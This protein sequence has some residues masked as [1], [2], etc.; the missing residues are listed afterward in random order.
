MSDVVSSSANRSSS[1]S[2]LPAGA[3]SDGPLTLSDDSQPPPSTATSLDPTSLPS[4]EALI[5]HPSTDLGVSVPSDASSSVHQTPLTPEVY[6]SGALPPGTTLGHYVIRS[7]IGGG[8][9]GRVYLATDS[10]LDRKVAIK[11]LPRQ[12]ANDQGTVARFMNEAK[13]AARLNHEH[14]AQVYFA[15][16]QAGIPFIVFEYVEGTNIRALVEENGVFTVPQAINFLIQI[17]HALAHAADHGVVHRDVKPSNILITS[18]GR[19]KLI[20]M[21]LARLLDPSE[22]KADLTASGVTLGTF[23]YIS[24]EQARDPRAADIRS[25]IY[26]LGCTFFYMLTG[27]PPF[28]EGTVLQKLLQHQG[29]LA[30]DVRTFQPNIP[31]EIALLIQKMMA[32]DPRQRFQTPGELVI[33]LVQVAEMLGLR[34]T[35]PGKL[36]WSMGTPARQSTWTKHVP[37]FAAVG[38]LVLLFLSLRIFWNSTPAFVFPPFPVDDSPVIDAVSTPETASASTPPKPIVPVPTFEQLSMSVQSPAWFDTIKSFVPQPQGKVLPSDVFRGPN[39]EPFGADLAVKPIAASWRS[40]SG[41]GNVRLFESLTFS[42]IQDHAETLAKTDGEGARIDLR[43]TVDPTKDTP[44]SFATLG[45]AIAE[46]GK[47]ATIELKC[48]GKIGID[49]I[50]VTGRNL[51]IAAAP[52]Y[53]PL[54]TFAS[55]D[56]L[57]FSQTSRSMFAV[58]NCELEFQDIAVEMHIDHNVLAPRW[59]LFELFGANTLTFNRCCLTIQNASTDF[60]AYHQEVA[61]FRNSPPLAGF[62]PIVT[63]SE[64]PA[65]DPDPFAAETTPDLRIRLNGCLLRGEANG[66]QCEMSQSVDF[67]IEHSF[68]ALAKSFVKTEDVKRTNDQQNVVLIALDR[69]FL[70][71]R[72]SFLRQNRSTDTSE[73]MRVD[74]SVQSSVIRLN[75]TP[76]AEL[77]GTIFPKASDSVFRWSGSGNYFQNVSLGWRLRPFSASSESEN[78]NEMSLADWR[79]RTG[80]AAP[81]AE[82]YLPEIRKPTSKLV[83]SDLLPNNIA[84]SFDIGPSRDRA[85]RLPTAWNTAE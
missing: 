82:L 75:Q 12:R 33:A 22:S 54:L 5:P 55:S 78:A 41:N 17:A 72:Q 24:P 10:A 39:S 62:E 49:P 57:S 73:P 25:D 28:P 81:T 13:S 36:D 48:N 18:T 60:S 47:Q 29:D 42:R 3:S 44:G 27:R 67:R 46:S 11:V 35:G 26:S 7:Y 37:W 77:Q 65:P 66:L 34:P 9:M 31:S 45:E 4:S 69:V 38:V 23:D 84:E 64:S 6:A 8:G 76:L 30:P 74:A 85:I 20:D 59:T 83:P 2:S 63:K 1:V 21:G 15:G 14:I 61:F 52:G 79:N 80:A 70:Y 71:D 58:G 19:A 50:S 56:T 40:E 32:K 51:K 16:E 53:A 68:V 43:L